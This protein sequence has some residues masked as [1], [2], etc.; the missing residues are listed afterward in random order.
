MNTH[1][2]LPGI[3]SRQHRMSGLQSAQNVQQQT[4][5]YQERLQTGIVL[6]TSEGDQVTLNAS[7]FSELDAFAYNRTGVVRTED[8]TSITQVHQ[9]EISLAS[10]QR[11]AFSVEGDLSEQELQDIEA[12]L[13]GLD[14]VISAM[15]KGDVDSVVQR[16]LDLGGLDSLSSFA[17]DIRYHRSYAVESTVARQATGPVGGGFVPGESGMSHSRQDAEPSIDLDTLFAHIEQQ[18]QAHKERMLEKAQGPI[19]RLFQHHLAAMAGESEENREVLHGVAAILE[20]VNGLIQGLTIPSRFDEQLS[21]AEEE[22]T[23]APSLPDSGVPAP[24]QQV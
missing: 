3:A 14:Q 6:Q 1:S 17:A 11:F 4:F 15:R 20:E 24:A 10:G 2:P 5:A 23:A 18:L 22:S 9:R 21:S 12:L 19:N 13:S 7:S 16:A 8:G